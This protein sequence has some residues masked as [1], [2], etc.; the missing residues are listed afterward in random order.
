LSA[1]IVFFPVWW[2][3]GLMELIFPLLAIPMAIHLARRRPIRLPPGFALWALFLV[4][5]L[6]GAVMLGVDPP[7]TMQAPASTRLIAYVVRLVEYLSMTVVLLYVGNLRDDELSRRRIV[8]MLGGFFLV[9]TVGGLLGTFRPAFEFTAP[10]ELLLPQGFRS[11]IYVQSLVHPEA[12]Q[13]Q[14]VLGYSAP[15][16]KAPFDYTNSWGNN[17][18]ILG[19]WFV[20]GWW[21]SGRPVRRAATAVVL[22]VAAVPVVYSLNRGVW[23]GIGFAVAY[24]AMRL[25]IR[26]RPVALV[27]AAAVVAVGIAAVLLSPLGQVIDER[28]DNPQSNSIRASLNEQSVQLALTSP[29]LGYGGTRNAEGSP[30]SIAVGRTSSCVRC[31][32]F[33]IGSTGQL[34]QLL[35][36]TGLVGTALYFGFFVLQLWRYRRDRTAIG[37]AGSLVILLML[38]FALFYNALASPLFLLMLSV[39]LLWRSDQAAQEAARRVS[40][41]GTAP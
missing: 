35:I 12:A 7:S 40:A 30:Q 20:A 28:L 29:I 26:G 5:V 34:W 1:L 21:G 8:Q 22:C 27:G 32:N 24:V 15:R 19:V 36:S 9:A 18:V 2:A 23:I 13:V 37:I 6:V 16:P 39:G 3:L 33:A 10:L 25:A 4:W 38:L 17:M 41:P 14:D 11:N 31:G